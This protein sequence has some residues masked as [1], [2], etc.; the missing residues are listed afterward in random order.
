MSLPDPKPFLLHFRLNPSSAPALCGLA[1]STKVPPCQPLPP[2]GPCVA[3]PPSGMFLASPY[4]EASFLARWELK[5]P[6]IPG[7]LQVTSEVREGRGDP[8]PAPRAISSASQFRVL[9][10]NGFATFLPAFPALSWAS[11]CSDSSKGLGSWE[12]QNSIPVK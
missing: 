6:F 3:V 4:K 12:W 11:L 2:P 5:Y 10:L 1:P 7:A 9:F 8:P